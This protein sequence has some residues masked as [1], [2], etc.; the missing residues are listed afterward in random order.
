MQGDPRARRGGRTEARDLSRARTGR[1]DQATSRAASSF[2][3]RSTRRRSCR[4]CARR[5]GRS[6]RTSRSRASRPSTTSSTRQ[7]SAPTQ[8]TALLGAFALLALLLASLGLY[9]VLSYAVTQRTNEIGAAHGAGRDVPRH[10]ALVQQARPGADARR[11]RHRLVL[12]FVAARLMTTLFYGFQP[13]YVPAVAAVSALLLAVAALA[14]WFPR[15][16]RRASTPSW[17]CSMN[18][19]LI[20]DQNGAVPARVLACCAV[21]SHV[22]AAAPPPDV[23]ARSSPTISTAASW[24]AITGTSLS[25][26]GPSTTS[27]R[28]TWIR[29]SAVGGDGALMI[30]PRFREGFKTPKGVASTSFPA[31]STPIKVTFTY[32][33]AAARM[34]LPAGAGL[35]P[36]FWALGDGRWPDPAR[37]TSWRTLA[38]RRGPASRCTVPAISATRRW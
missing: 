27:S 10:P 33:T 14:F 35:W 2:A 34:K 29:R 11:P 8:N 1:P 26:A 7:L 23:R 28:P 5:S 17:R 16:A 3:R 18:S 19:S 22:I 13:D 15:A 24:I 4:R 31:G 12:A 38:T 21:P 32:G 30:R 36:A 25:R 20:G 6:T 9:G 37:S